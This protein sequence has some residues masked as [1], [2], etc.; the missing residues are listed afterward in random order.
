MLGVCYIIKLENIRQ[1]AIVNAP[2]WREFEW[3]RERKKL[4]NWN[5]VLNLLI[6]HHS[7]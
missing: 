7:N 1:N 2:T 5:N 4:S 6:N 3:E